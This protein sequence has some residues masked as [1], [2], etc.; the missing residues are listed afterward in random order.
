[1]SGLMSNQCWLYITRSSGLLS[2][3]HLDRLEP[4]PA[5]RLGMTHQ[6]FSRPLTR[7]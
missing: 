7:R 1:M 4:T 5:T 6:S 2:F 3:Q